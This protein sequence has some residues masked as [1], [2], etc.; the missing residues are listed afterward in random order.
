MPTR[1]WSWHP[2]RG[3]VFVSFCYQVGYIVCRCGGRRFDNV[4]ILLDRDGGVVK[5]DGLM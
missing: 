5:L 1:A 3:V 4:V 2:V